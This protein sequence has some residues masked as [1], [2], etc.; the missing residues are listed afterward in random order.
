[1]LLSATAWAQGVSVEKGD[2]RADLSGML[3]LEAYDTSAPPPGL[4]FGDGGG[5]LNPRLTV[6]GG[7]RMGQRAFA[8]VQLRADRGFD[9]LSRSRD[10][11]ADEYFFRYSVS[12]GGRLHLQA[13]KSATVVGNWVA[14]HYSWENAFVNAPLPYENVTI[15]W[16]RW[17]PANADAFLGYLQQPARKADMLPIIWGPVYAT[18]L[19]AFGASGRWDYAVEFK[20]AGLS[21]RPSDWDLGTP[22]LRRPTVSGRFGYRPSAAWAL[23]WSASRGHYAVADPDHTLRPGTALRDFHQTTLGSDLS[24]SRRHLQI[25]AEGFWS[26]FGVQ[27]VG[28]VQTTAY[29]V[30]GKYKLTPQLFAALRWGQQFFSELDGTHWDGRA[31][32]AEV[33]VGYRFN[34]RLQAKA[35]YGLTTGDRPVAQGRRLAAVQLTARF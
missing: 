23:G 33:A 25:W 14:R 28:D 24:Y 32:R 35:Q 20:N 5:F 11:R 21:S 10:L 12:Q 8:F 17:Q 29:Y 7:V 18:G 6:F 16:D 19:S 3:D 30:E 31:S 9:P 26:R 27:Q 13:G 2:L 1:M 34:R 22:G 4:V 15:I